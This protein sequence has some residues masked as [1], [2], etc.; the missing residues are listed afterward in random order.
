MLDDQAGMLSTSQYELV[1]NVPLQLASA[2]GV[3]D[4]ARKWEVRGVGAPHDLTLTA[5]P[6]EITGPGERAI[7]V[8]ISETRES[9][10]SLRKFIL[11]P[12]GAL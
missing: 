11:L 4:V 10:S 12:D 7:A 2:A 6:L 9:G 1:G 3:A 8:Y 5:A